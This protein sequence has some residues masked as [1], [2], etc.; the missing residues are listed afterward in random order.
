[1]LGPNHKHIGVFE[2]DEVLPLVGKGRRVPFV[3][4]GVA[5]E[6]NMNVHAVKLWG[7]RPLH[8]ALCGLKIHYFL[9]VQ[10]PDNPKPQWRE[11]VLLGFSNLGTMFNTDHIVPRSLGGNDDLDNLQ[12]ACHRCNQKKGNRP[13]WRPTIHESVRRRKDFHE[14]YAEVA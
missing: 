10:D 14:L 13:N 8:C 5:Y 1:M 4:D 6:V 2:I 12:I 11:P 9:L 7:E 3:V